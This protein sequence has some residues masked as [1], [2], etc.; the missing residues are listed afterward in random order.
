M[1]QAMPPRTQ[2]RP[3]RIGACL[4]L[5]GKY[6]LFGKQAAR[7]LQAWSAL[8]GD[9]HLSIEDDR[10]EAAGVS[11]SLRRLASGSD[12]LVGPYSTELTR[13]AATVASAIDCLVWN[14][15]GAGDDAQAGAPGRMVSLLTPASRYSLPFL[16]RAATEDV[17]APIFLV[18]GRGRF[19][20]QVTAGAEAMAER[21]RL[22]TVHLGPDQPLPATEQLSVWD[23]F[24]AGSFY[25]DVARIN[26]ARA[27]PVPPRTVCAVAAGVRQFGSAIVNP[28]GIFGIAQWF[29]GAEG[30]AGVGPDEA[31]FL[32][33]YFDLFGESPEY[34][35]VQAAAAAIVSSH[36]TRLC[37]ETNPARLWSAAAALDTSTLFGKFMIDPATGAQVKHDVQLVRWTASGLVLEDG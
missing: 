26:Q 17:Q 10:S 22:K 34:P 27:L 6:A 23:L 11:M 35:A 15:G 19:G 28:Q 32:A 5:T 18:H 9:L 3:L 12:L 16:Q 29:P 21:L 14:Q 2:R 24:C 4:S 20:R 25:E 8:A 1:T 36:C 30:P 37:G 33:A 13:V 7:G 31:R